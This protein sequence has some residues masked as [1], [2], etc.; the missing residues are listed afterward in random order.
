MSAV[1]G[2]NSSRIRSSG[3][4]GNNTASSAASREIDVMSNLSAAFSAA[5]NAEM[6][7]TVRIRPSSSRATKSSTLTPLI[8]FLLLL[9]PMRSHLV[10]VASASVLP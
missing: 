10:A 6:D 5:T 1:A 8:R 7:D 9:V 2:P 4:F 3:A